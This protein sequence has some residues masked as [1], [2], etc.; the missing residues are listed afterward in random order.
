MLRLYR[1]APDVTTLGPGKRF[2]VWVQGCM[3]HC[4]GCMST[5]T[6]P[7]EGGYEIDEQELADRMQH[8]DFEGLTISGGEPLLQC[9]ALAR[10]IRLVKEK[11]DVG[12]ILYTGMR[13]QELD[14]SNP[15]IKELLALIDLMIDGEYIPQ[16]D[17]NGALRGSSNQNA[18]FFTERYKDSVGQCFGQPGLR[19]QQLQIDDQGVLLIGLKNNTQ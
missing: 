9:R 19:R 10:L 2:C 7:L 4:P 12:V 3:K 15:D 5:E 13:Y 8:F 16:K 14:Q 18:H 11:R 1:V 17:D 6:W